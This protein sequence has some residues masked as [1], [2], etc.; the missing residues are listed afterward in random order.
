[1]KKKLIDYSI[2]KLASDAKFVLEDLNKFSEN[3]RKIE[4]NLRDIKFNLPFR[5]CISREESKPGLP[6]REHLEFYPGVEYY[7]TEVFWFLSWEPY[8]KNKNYRLL[9]ISEEKEHVFSG[10]DEFFKIFEFQCKCTFK[11]PLQETNIKIKLKYSEYL[12]AFVDAF[13][14]YLIDARTSVELDSISFEDNTSLE[15]NL[16][17]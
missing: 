6:R 16:P 2:V 17:F 4:N 9:L 1:M 11:K 10:I 12:M 3:I 15:D 5:Y 7:G 13:R 8:E 14:K